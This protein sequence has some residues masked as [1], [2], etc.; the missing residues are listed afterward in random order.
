MKRAII[1]LVGVLVMITL[2]GCNKK[3]NTMSPHFFTADAMWEDAQAVQK[4]RC[5]F[6]YEES[7]LST[8]KGLN[9]GDKTRNTLMCN[10]L[11]YNNE[12]FVSIISNMIIDYRFAQI[13]LIL[14]RPQSV[15]DQQL[16]DGISSLAVTIKTLAPYAEIL[17]LSKETIDCDAVNSLQLGGFKTEL[18]LNNSDL[19]N[20]LSEKVG[21]DKIG[22]THK[23]SQGGMDEDYIINNREQIE[24]CDT[25]I[26]TSSN[27]DSALKI[28]IIGDSISRGYR[29]LVQERLNTALVSY[30]H[31][32][33]GVDDK[34]FYRELDVILSA[35]DF[36]VI[37]FNIGIHTHNLS[38]D[39]YEIKM[40]E[41]IDYLHKKEIKAKLL[42]ANSTNYSLP[43]SN[44]EMVIYDEKFPGNVDIIARNKKMTEV[45]ANKNVPYLDLFDYVV[46]NKPEKTDTV[47]F[48]NY[49]ALA[50]QVIA[51]IENNL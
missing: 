46:K 29:P 23:R 4:D 17:F 20:S 42:F 22:L 48:K 7:S 2:C 34:A 38:P 12:Q 18:Y 31:T 47:H 10:N 15:T 51:F 28:L 36:D 26:K 5:L 41:L 1:L 30:M 3:E 9:M 16:K 27:N 37:H 39:G 6:V 25:G 44:G 14:P 45:C 21:G 32:S 19:R 35:V 24:W 13:F 43:N 49:Q 33:R 8:V 40:E 50:N 11:Y